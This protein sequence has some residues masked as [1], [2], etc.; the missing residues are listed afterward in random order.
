M[1]GFPLFLFW[2]DSALKPGAII[3]ESYTKK[4]WIIITQ[5]GGSRIRE[6]AAIPT[7]IKVLLA[8]F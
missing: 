3:D 4:L 2:R 5:L 7:V 1:Q 6:S 8:A